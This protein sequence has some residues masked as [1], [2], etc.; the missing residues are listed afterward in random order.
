MVH[1]YSIHCLLQHT[2][3]STWLTVTQCTADTGNT[4]TQAPHC[5]SM[6]SLYQQKHIWLMVPHL[7]PST[8]TQTNDSLHFNAQPI[9]E[10]THT[11]THTHTG[12]R[13]LWFNTWLFRIHT[14]IH[15]SLWLKHSLYQPPGTHTHTH[16]E[17]YSSH[18]N[19]MHSIYQ[20]TH[21]HTWLPV[22]ECTACS[23]THTKTHT[24]QIDSMHSLYQHKHTLHSDS[25]LTFYN[26]HRP[27]HT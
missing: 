15:G 24:G 6:C 3:A 9:P 23:N 25:M 22:I 8:T 26:T 4:H 12:K 1:C 11:Q 27:T 14:H 10:H 16:T 19:T 17:T 2:H 7:A 13:S 5:D 21:T 18:L 20:H